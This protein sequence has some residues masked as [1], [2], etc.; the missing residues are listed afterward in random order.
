MFYENIKSLGL[1][2]IMV[3]FAKC[4]TNCCVIRDISVSQKTDNQNNVYAVLF[5]KFTMHFIYRGYFTLS[6]TVYFATQ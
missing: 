2:P 1:S 6:A 3:L 4:D 5:F